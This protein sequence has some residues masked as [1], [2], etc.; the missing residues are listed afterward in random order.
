MR[1]MVVVMF[2]ALCAACSEQPPATSEPVDYRQMN[3]DAEGPGSLV[4]LEAMDFAFIS[5][6]GLSGAGCYIRQ[7]GGTDLLFIAQDEAAYFLL[8][9]RLRT[10]APHA[11]EQQFPYGVSDHYDGRQYSVELKLDMDSGT[12]TGPEL[13]EYSGG[14][15]IR[16]AKERIVYEYYDTVHCGA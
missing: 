7:P 1:A 4:K 5:E 13:S 16:D 2:A 8:G 11:V 9:N 15:T 14:L 12:S 6:N 3:E 10:L